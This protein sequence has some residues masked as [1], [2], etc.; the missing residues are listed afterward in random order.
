MIFEV[1]ESE[2]EA[3]AEQALLRA[4][5]MLR[6]GQVRPAV[7]ELLDS[8]AANKDLREGLARRAILLCFLMIGEQPEDEE[9]LSTLRRR[10]ATLVY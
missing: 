1:R 6:M 7:E 5:E 4:A 8:I 9:E 2:T 10:L 3:P